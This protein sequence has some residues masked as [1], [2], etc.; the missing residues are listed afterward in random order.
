MGTASRVLVDA[1]AC[2]VRREVERVAARFN[3]QV[4]Y[5]ANSAQELAEGSRTCVVRVADR[6][7]A[8]DFAMVSHCRAGDVVVTDDM[9]LAAMALA[10][11]ADAVSSRGRRFA[12]DAM[13]ALLEQRHAARKARRAGQ[14][15]RG[16]RPLT[17]A[18]RR[19]FTRTLA[20][21]LERSG[22]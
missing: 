13:P 3:A 9:G 16:P 4:V 19:R 12:T 20:E 8:A 10:A 5:F 21:I 1:D 7:D 18:D 15:T 14:R 17:A 6:R 11:G 22:D 2:P